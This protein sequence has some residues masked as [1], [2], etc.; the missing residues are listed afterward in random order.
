MKQRQ[1]W[2]IEK[3]ELEKKYG[4]P[5]DDNG[6]PIYPEPIVDLPLEL[7]ERKIKNEPRQEIKK[8]K[9]ENVLIKVMKKRGR[10]P[11]GK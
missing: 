5:V 11:H 2:H 7:E 6:N 9:K 1:P 8:E 4:V 3:V 10:K